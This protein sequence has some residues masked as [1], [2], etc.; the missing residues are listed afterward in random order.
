MS[1]AQIRGLLL[2]EA[3]L[4]LLRA[5]GY[6][7]VY[8]KGSDPTLEQEGHSLFVKGRGERHQIDAIAD[9]RIQPPFSNPQRLLLEAKYYNGRRVGLNVIR[10][11]VGVLN[12]VMQFFVAPLG[13]T[14]G[15]LRYHYQYA[16]VSATMFSEPSQRYAYAHDIF[17]I[18]LGSSPYFHRLLASIRAVAEALSDSNANNGSE[19]FGGALRHLIRQ[20]LTGETF[21][22]GEADEIYLSL[23]KFTQECLGLKFGLIAMA[24]S[25]FPLF[26]VPTQDL[27]LQELQ[28]VVQVR[29][30]PSSEG[31]F[32][33][34]P[35]GRRLFSFDLP[36]EMTALYAERGQ[37]TPEAALN[38]KQQELYEIKAVITEGQ[39]LRIVRFVLDIPWIEA[40]RRRQ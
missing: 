7:P 29:I 10:N 23:N 27:S 24:A 40:L 6:G 26:L 33:T 16:V 36:D 1:S 35:Q 25:G 20:I 13:H 19:D 18:P 21:D 8:G 22:W 12:D 15:K 30:R 9:Y 34:T 5:A 31:W 14:P 39:S 2:E 32:L 28:S 17:L 38:M 11:A 3:M 4:Y 37:L